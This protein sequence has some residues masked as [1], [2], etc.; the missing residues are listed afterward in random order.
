VNFSHFWASKTHFRI[1][2]HENKDKRFYYLRILMPISILLL[3]IGNP[4]KPKIDSPSVQDDKSLIAMKFCTVSESTAEK[5][6]FHQAEFKF[7]SMMS[8]R[9]K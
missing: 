3:E 7:S 1:R 6:Y 8:R 4:K 9:L 5:T 2:R